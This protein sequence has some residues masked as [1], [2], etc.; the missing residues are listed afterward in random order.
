MT[1]ES[2][3]VTYF[4]RL[5]PEECWAL[6]SE[7]QVG[8]IAWHDGAGISVVPVNFRVYDG[9]V[10]FHTSATSTL[11]RLVD[12]HDVSFQVEDIDHE[13]AVGWSVLIR[14]RSAAAD[15]SIPSVSWLAG[16]RPVGIAV[17]STRID[18]RVVS[19]TKQAR[20]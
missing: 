10:V 5:E 16:D 19:G 9:T 1:T 8:R 14:G 7:A 3:P 20:S 17:E 6:L 13:T 15:E 4:S 12:G 2:D 11:A 18:G